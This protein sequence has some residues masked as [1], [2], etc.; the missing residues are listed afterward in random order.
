MRIWPITKK[1]AQGKFLI[2]ARCYY[3]GTLSAQGIVHLDAAPPGYRCRQPRI[4]SLLPRSLLSRA[5]RDKGLAGILGV[6]VDA[7]GEFDKIDSLS[8][9]GSIR[10]K[11]GRFGELNLLKVGVGGV[12]QGFL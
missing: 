1:M 9:T 2:C 6:R 3:G 5:Q 8:G 7:A 11:D 12:C 10:L 4:R